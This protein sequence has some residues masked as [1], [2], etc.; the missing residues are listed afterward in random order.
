M[1]SS[2]TSSASASKEQRPAPRKK[3]WAP[4]VRTGCW[5][6]RS[7]HVKCDEARPICMRCQKTQRKCAGYLDPIGPS[8]QLSTA[9]AGCCPEGLRLNSYF[10]HHLV[11]S[12]ADE[13]DCDYWR[14]YMP[15]FTQTV[16]AIWHATNAL[17]ALMWAGNGDPAAAGAADCAKL[18]KLAVV[19]HS[20]A[21]NDVL[22]L[23]RKN[24]LSVADK[25]V[26]VVANF[27]FCAIAGHPGNIETFMA[28]HG[29]TVRLI[30]HWR[31]WELVDSSAEAMHL[32]HLFIKSVRIREES[33][34]L[35]CQTPGEG[36]ED[37][38]VFLQKRPLGSVIK[39]YIELEMLWISLYAVLDGFFIRSSATML[40]VEATNTRR[41]ELQPLFLIWERRYQAFLFCTPN[42][43]P[44]GAAALS[45]RYILTRICFEMHLQPFEHVAEET[46]W[47]SF[48][49]EFTLAWRIIEETLTAPASFT[50]S[51]P[52]RFRPSLRTSLQFI[53]RYCRKHSL[54]H[55]AAALLRSELPNGQSG[56]PP[57]TP[58][59]VE[60]IITLE[61]SESKTCGQV[62]RCQPGEFIC[63]WHRVAKVHAISLE[64]SECHEFQCLTVGDIMDGRPGTTVRSTAI[65]WA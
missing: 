36:W 55:A 21:M 22:R 8:L 37:A 7:R 58:L 56:K 48:E 19:Q 4:R 59:L 24:T 47:D 5:T 45:V 44:V 57:T 15:R 54:R 34:L 9:P 17:S 33:L 14:Y 26:I 25:A 12:A 1:D 3:R 27:F 63:N 23:T 31:F 18:H 32:F 10:L 60:S 41:A 6:C 30:R 11:R 46:C 65:L 40:D 29:K 52:A 28:M 51:S 16:P 61:E 38:V 13:F 64:E 2:A 53:A 62:P 42:I 39:A 35:T 20:A 49:Q 43:H 50:K